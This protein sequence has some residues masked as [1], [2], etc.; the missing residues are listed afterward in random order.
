MFGIIVLRSL[1]RQAR[2]THIE[3]RPTHI[4]VAESFSQ[5]QCFSIEM[6]RSLPVGRKDA[7]RVKTEAHSLL[8]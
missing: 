3:F 7:H 1:D 4:S 6:N 8:V 5:A 2:T